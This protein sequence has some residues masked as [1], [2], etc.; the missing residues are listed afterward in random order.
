MN[1]KEF[2]STIGLGAVGVLC[3]GCLGAC[4]SE[5]AV[6]APVSVDFTL[7]MSTPAYQSLAYPGGYVYKDG[8]IVAHTTTGAYIAVSATCTHQGG[9]VTYDP[10]ANRLH[11]PNHGSNFATDGSVQNGPATAPLRQYA[12]SVNGSLL[13]VTAYGTRV[14]SQVAIL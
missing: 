1:R 4:K 5:D 8:V 12:V 6:T 14:A 10:A 2:L 13:H 7:D 3:A 11:C 9:T